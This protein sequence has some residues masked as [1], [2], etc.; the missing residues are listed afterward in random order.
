MLYMQW[1]YASCLLKSRVLKFELYVD[2]FILYA[3]SAGMRW[4]S[5]IVLLAIALSVVAPPSLP[6]MAAQGGQAEIGTLDVCRSAT[7]A[8][9]SNGDMPCIISCMNRP[10]PQG[11]SKVPAVAVPRFNPFCIAF[12]DERPP[13]S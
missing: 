6:L 8:L 9:S 2:N 13:K 3:Y 10:L 12:Q 7:P 5:I 1:N 4:Q 11:L